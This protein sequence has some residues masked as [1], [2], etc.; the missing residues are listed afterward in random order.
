MDR[1]LLARVRD[2]IAEVGN[3]HCDMGLFVDGCVTGSG[4]PECGT[5]ACIAG[6][7][8]AVARGAFDQSWHWNESPALD[9]GRLL[10][11]TDNELDS[12]FFVHEWPSHYLELRSAEGDAK[13]MLSLLDAILDGRVIFNDRGVL[14]DLEAELADEVEEMSR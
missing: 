5:S 13:G 7:T 10:G 4:A 12:L 3:E 1:E 2:R 9:A 8:L 6:W 11:L 14:V